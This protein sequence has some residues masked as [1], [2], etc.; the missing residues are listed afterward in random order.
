MRVTVETDGDGLARIRM[1]RGSGNAID[2]A[3]ARALLDAARECERTRARAVL[4]TGHGRSFCVGGDLKEFA[5]LS[6]ERGERLAAHLADVT[7]AL[8]GALRIL[9]GLD[10]PLVVAAQGAVAGAGL[11]LVAAA[12]VSL[13][14]ADAGFTAAYTAI[15]YT[16]D[17]GVSWSLPRLVGPRRAVDLLLTNRRVTAAEALGMGLVSRVVEPERLHEEA[18]RTAGALARG[19][20]EAYGTTRRLV[21]RALTAGLDEHLDAEARL[22]AEAAVSAE[23]REGVAAFLGGRRP[24]FAGPG[25]ARPDSG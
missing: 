7:D 16:P 18:V 5:T 25:R 23:G 19:A 9:A 21:G 24:D 12:D 4:L 1:C 15:G 22:L 17:A 13:A 11:G 8:H 2:L 20:T 10:A 6:G 14:A 3:M